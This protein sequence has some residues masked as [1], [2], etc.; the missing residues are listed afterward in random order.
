MA[1]DLPGK[2][3][4]GSDRISYIFVKQT[5]PM[6]QTFNCFVHNVFQ[7]RGGS[8]DTGKEKPCW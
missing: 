4:E 5:K 8:R 3:K 2:M 1:L 7:A 6:E